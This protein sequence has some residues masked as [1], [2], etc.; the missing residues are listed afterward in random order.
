MKGAT[1]APDKALDKTNAVLHNAG[2]LDASRASVNTTFIFIK[3]LM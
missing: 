1:N 3:V 2:M